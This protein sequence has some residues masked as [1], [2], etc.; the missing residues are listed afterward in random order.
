MNVAFLLTLVRKL[1][2]KLPQAWPHVLHIMADLKAIMA[3]MVDVSPADFDAANSFGT[4]SASS[5]AG[6][7]EDT[8]ELKAACEQSGVDPAECEAVCNTF[9]AAE[10]AVAA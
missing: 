5:T 9:A 6:V 7:A 8:Q 3:L 1:G 10:R 2:P 4:A